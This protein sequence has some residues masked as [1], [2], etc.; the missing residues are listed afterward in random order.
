MT[1]TV[2]WILSLKAIADALIGLGVIKGKNCQVKSI[3]RNGTA[4]VITFAWYDEDEEL[5]QMSFT[6][7]DGVDGIN[8]VDGQDG[9]P[10]DPGVNGVSVVSAEITATHHLVFTMS[11]DTTIDAGVISGGGEG[12][13]NVIANPVLEGDET[14]L[15]SLGIDGTN[16]KLATGGTN[17]IANPVMSGTEEIATGIQIGSEKFIFPSTSTYGFT[18]S[19]ISMLS[20]ILH[21]GLYSSDQS[22]AIDAFITSLS[23]IPEPTEK[24]LTSITA[25]INN[26]TV[27]QNTTYIPNVSVTAHYDDGTTAN[28]SAQ[29]VFGTIDTATAGAKTLTISYTENDVT[30]TTSGTVTVTAE[31]VPVTLSS[32]SATKAKMSYTTDET[33]STDDVVVTAHYSDN[34]TANVTSSATIGTVDISTA[35]TKTLNISYTED[36]V[37]KTATLSITVTAEPV[38]VTKVSISAT[39]TKTSYT[40][41][42]TFSTDDVVVT[43][44]YSDSSISIVPHSESD[45]SIGVVDTSTTGT[46]TLLIRYDDDGNTLETTITITV[47]EASEKEYLTTQYVE[48]RRVNNGVMGSHTGSYL[49]YVPV[50]A[51]TTYNSDLS[52]MNIGYCSA[53]YVKDKVVDSVIL[54]YTPDADGWLCYRVDTSTQ[55]DLQVYTGGTSETGEY[56]YTDVIPSSDAEGTFDWQSG[57]GIDSTNGGLISDENSVVSPYIVLESGQGVV[58]KHTLGSSVIVARY[59][60]NDGAVGAFLDTGGAGSNNV[61]T[62][63]HS[64]GYIFRFTHSPYRVNNPETFERRN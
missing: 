14:E 43:M 28:V 47:S 3:V 15:E 10:G 5:Q 7:Y 54:P 39:K 20:G 25:V 18:A 17:V 26:P 40:V 24:V 8:G 31:P 53:G 2:S 56:Q 38:P 62:N 19:Q 42:E 22:S 16:Y 50:T 52:N 4:T 34:T 13:T 23:E 48:G 60:N 11:D 37:T 46:K 57:Y 33:F 27:E 9:A 64:G 12:G 32:I 36:G 59:A 58:F 1:G 63:A 55:L 44:H 61:Y 30:K 49:C 6:M 35:G 51:G 21:A 41:G 45:L 29:A